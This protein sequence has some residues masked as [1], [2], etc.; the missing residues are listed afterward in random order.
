MSFN[1]FVVGYFAAKKDLYELVTGELN[2]KVN[3]HSDYQS[4]EDY[5]TSHVVVCSSVHVQLS[6]SSILSNLEYEGE[7]YRGNEGKSA[8]SNEQG[9]GH[10]AEGC[11]EDMSST[12]NEPKYAGRDAKT[13]CWSAKAIVKSTL[14]DCPYASMLEVGVS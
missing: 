1:E 9:E 12:K 4:N 2:S 8:K 3:D 14:I 5:P 13:C 10:E 7:D 6:L 11:L